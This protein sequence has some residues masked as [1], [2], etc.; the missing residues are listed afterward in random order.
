[1][2][3]LAEVKESHANHPSVFTILN[4]FFFL[5]LKDHI[6]NT[7]LDVI[8]LHS[9]WPE[10]SV[11]AAQLVRQSPFP[12][13]EFLSYT[14]A[15]LGFAVRCSDVYWGVNKCLSFLISLQLTANAL[16]ALLVFSGAS[17]LY[18]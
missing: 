11:S 17:I 13:P 6:W 15:L 8:F 2:A 7:D 1:M 16:C 10:S 4:L 12:S 3:S 5:F 14:L 9:F 18:K